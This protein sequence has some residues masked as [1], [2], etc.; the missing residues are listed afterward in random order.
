M[1]ELVMRAWFLVEGKFRF[2]DNWHIDCLCEHLEAIFYGQIRNI[3]INMPPRHAKSLLICVFW[4]VWC[5][6]K[7]PSYRFL[8]TSYKESL[9]ARDA[10]KSRTILESKWFQDRWGDKF[11]IKDDENSKI[12]YVND[13]TGH[14]ISTSVGG[15]ATGEGGDIIVCFPW[16]ELVATE[17]GPVE[18]GKLVDSKLAVRVWSYDTTT[19]RTELKPVLGWHNNPGRQ[20][21]EVVLSDGASVRCTPDHR[22]WTRNRGWVPA[23]DLVAGDVLPSQT[24][25]DRENR[26]P[27]Y[28][29]LS[30]YDSLRTRGGVNP[31]NQIFGEFCVSESF[32]SFSVIGLPE[33]FGHTSPCGPVSDLL[34]GH[35]RYAESIGDSRSR[36]VAF[37]NLDHFFLGQFGSG[38]TFEDG[39][40]PVPLGVVNILTPGSILQILPATIGSDAVLVTDFLAFGRGTVEGQHD[41]LMDTQFDHDPV[42]TRVEPRVA[43][44]A[45]WRLNDLL[46]DGI[47]ATVLS[48]RLAGLASDS[49]QVRHT[50]PGGDGDRHPVLVRHH[51]YSER[52]YC[53]TVSDHYS[54]LVGLG[55]VICHNCDDPH[56]IN[57]IDSETNRENVIDWWDQ[58]IGSRGN[59]PKRDRRVIVMQRLGENDLSGHVLAQ[60]LGYENLVLPARYEPKRLFMWNPGIET[61]DSARAKAGQ[62]AILPTRLQIE[63]PDLRD[64]RTEE[65]EVLWV[66]RFDEPELR[67]LEK[68]MGTWGAAGQLQQR[69]SPA[70]G[71]IIKSSDFCYFTE[72]WIDQ[73]DAPPVQV[74]KLTLPDGSFKR[75]MAKYCDKFQV[76][77]T[78]MCEG[79]ENDYTVIGTLYRTPYNELLLYDVFRDKLEVP[80]Q[81]GRL[82]TERVKHPDL[83]FQAIENKQSG[84]GIIQTGKLKGTNFRVLK[85]EGDKTQRMA[86]TSI[87][88]QNRSIFHRA[89]Q[90]WLNAYEN[91]VTKFPNATHDDQADM[92]AYAGI[93]LT[94]DALLTAGKEVDGLIVYPAVGDLREKAE[95]ANMSE[96]LYSQIYLNWGDDEDRTPAGDRF[97]ASL[98][99]L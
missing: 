77:D 47:D 59:D 64:P 20:I 76:A 82:M 87:L 38:A 88:Y 24:V 98:F 78:A 32:A 5:W 11:R 92:I 1:K 74:F 41:A 9:S 13:K 70:G 16:D 45:G 93:L 2:Q 89:G 14:R 34:D 30:G 28:S 85:A 91:E 39:E 48:G 40:C 63:R 15:G 61:I 75:Y 49:A 62:E 66:G 46:F 68:T 56:K 52:T 37:D 60:E 58:V 8:Y 90:P 18:I 36:V 29:G 42:D 4:F 95:K 26:F 23:V 94:T 19:G 81:Y 69:P 3:V 73:P 96:E 35:D 65:N 99:D 80:F 84:V 44:G 53:L 67:S 25:F 79:Q 43:V 12:R 86:A 54:M 71:G 97:A 55:Q 83:L 31:P 17:N 6:I 51:G 72:E 57:E 22:I 21:V 7:D 27:V 33:P 50:V 10:T